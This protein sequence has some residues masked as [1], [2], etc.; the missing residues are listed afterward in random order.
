M[1]F[2]PIIGIAAAL[3]LSGCSGMLADNATKQAQSQCA[4]EGKQFLPTNVEKHDNP[5]YSS[6]AVS[7]HC[8]GPGDPGY[9]APKSSATQQQN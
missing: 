8:V 9:V 1:R 6:A 4:A 3:G 7:G 2:L 5:I